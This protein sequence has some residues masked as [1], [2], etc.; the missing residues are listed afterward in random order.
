MVNLPKSLPFDNEIARQTADANR[1]DAALKAGMKPQNNTRP[2]PT[3]A[4]AP[5]RRRVSPAADR[6]P[7]RSL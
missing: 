2:T 4:Y 1:A 7:S 3:T 5:E 6:S